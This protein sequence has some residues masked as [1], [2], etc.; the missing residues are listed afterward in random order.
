MFINGIPATSI[1]AH[2]RGLLYGDGVFRTFVRENG[3]TRC[4]L[5]HFR[6]LAEDC[7]V[8]A[9][10]CPDQAL[11][12]DEVARLPLDC[13]GKIIVTRGPGVRGYA[14]SP[15]MEP[16][17]I[18][19]ASPLPAYPE[20]YRSSGI[21]ACLCDLRLGHAP[22][23]AGVKHLN[24]LEN[25]LARMEWDDPE[26]VEG[27]L[28]DESGYV[29]EGVMSN[30]FAWRE[31]VLSTPDLSLCGVAG[32]QRERV[33]EFADLAGIPVS[34]RRLSLAEFMASEAIIMSNSVMGLW[35]ILEFNGKVW[36]VSSL[37]GQ[38]R[39]LLDSRND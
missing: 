34:V 11:L 3:V 35:Q 16:T 29:I 7:A 12:E 2:D 24:R 22:R 31:G 21:K 6:K 1:P 20:H 33:L 9:I 28:L 10:A 23:L 13:V 32:V 4:W 26:I 30:L 37:A 15:G 36:P 17:R 27:V 19:S 39:A 38:L 18:V 8:L 5:R 14:V 25:V